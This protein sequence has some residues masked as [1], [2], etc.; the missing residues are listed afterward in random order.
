MNHTNDHEKKHHEEEETSMH[1]KIVHEKKTNTKGGGI[2]ISK[3]NLLTF[4]VIILIL[5]IA[6]TNRGLVVAAMVNGSPVSRLAVIESLEKSS[7][8]QALNTLITKKV[9][10]DEVRKRGITVTEDEIEA[11]IK[12][13]SE[14]ISAQGSTL[15][16]AL[17]SQGVLMEDFRKNQ[18]TQIEVE[19]LLGDKIAVTD[20]DIE[21]YIKDNNIT[22]PQDQIATAKAQLR[23]QLKREKL[24]IEGQKLVDALKEAARITYFVDYVK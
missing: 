19:K 15:E 9:I 1:E 17:A 16:D 10:A 18:R 22:I 12:Y 2:V 20:A 5:A 14:Q 3:K 13:I 7:G 23:D 11:G 4:T 8:K 24:N 6:Y 21:K